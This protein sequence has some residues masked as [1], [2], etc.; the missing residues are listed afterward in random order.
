MMASTSKSNLQKRDWSALPSDIMSNILS[1]LCINDILENAQKVC[2]AWRIVS[3][4]PAMWRVINMNDLFDTN[5]SVEYYYDDDDHEEKEEEEVDSKREISREKVC[6]HLVDRSQ[7]QLVDLTLVST[8]NAEI[9]LHVAER[10]CQLRRLEVVN[11]YRNWVEA[12]IKFP[13]LEELNLYSVNITKEEIEA[14]GRYCPLLKTFKVNSDAPA[15]LLGDDSD[16]LIAIGFKYYTQYNELPIAIAKTLHELKHLELI[17]SNM[18]NAALQ[19]ILDGCRH[20]ETLDLR[21]CVNIHLKG[22]LG[23]R[24]SEQIKY[25]K[26]PKDPLKGIPH[27]FKKRHGYSPNELMDL[28]FNNPVKFNRIMCCDSFFHR[29]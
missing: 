29:E 23:K 5:E 19:A 9:L 2:T 14:V 20:L 8:N 1:R 11:G 28:L 21:G 22:D 17:G 13:L 10:S 16:P 25:L 3:K 6:K 12:L 27:I 7:G 26:R 24:C 4:D 18:T 15:L